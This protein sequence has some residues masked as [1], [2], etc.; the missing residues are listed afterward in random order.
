LD[1]KTLEIKSAKND[2]LIEKLDSYVKQINSLNIKLIQAEDQLNEQKGKMHVIKLYE[3]EKLI[4]LTRIEELN[5]IIIQDREK[6]KEVETT[7]QETYHETYY[8]KQA[9]ADC[10]VSG[11][12]NNDFESQVRDLKAENDSLIQINKELVNKYSDLVELIENEE[13]YDNHCLINYID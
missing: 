4:L 11:I 1:K 7:K 5:Y 10:D 8:A 6:Y 2:M 9:L 3:S 13:F 12:S